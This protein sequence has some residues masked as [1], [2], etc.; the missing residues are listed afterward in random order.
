MEDDIYIYI[1]IYTHTVTSKEKRVLFMPE[2]CQEGNV[3]LDHR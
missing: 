3:E 1:Y 2:H